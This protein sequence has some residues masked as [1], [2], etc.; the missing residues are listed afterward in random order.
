MGVSPQLPGAGDRS[1]RLGSRSTQRGHLM[2]QDK[3]PR[4]TDMKRAWAEAR[5]L[6][7][8]HRRSLS[9]G[10]ALMLMVAVGYYWGRSFIGPILA[11]TRGTR[12]LAEGNLHETLAVAG[13]KIEWEYVPDGEVAGWDIAGNLKL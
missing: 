7:W 13:R 10:L 3:K 5:A 2:D 6:M 1:E 11:L 9:I 8:H 12:A 4:K